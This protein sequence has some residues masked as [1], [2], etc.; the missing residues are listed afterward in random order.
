M[1]PEA[2]PAVATSPALTFANITVDAGTRYSAMGFAK[3]LGK[4]LHPRFLPSCRGT[5][6]PVLTLCVSHGS[7]LPAHSPDRDPPWTHRG[8]GSGCWVPG[9]VWEGAHTCTQDSP[10]P[11]LSSECLSRAR[12]AAA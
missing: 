8:L 10:V 6:R 2:K 11:Q 1:I 12:S 7:G 4:H 3:G 5:P 9:L